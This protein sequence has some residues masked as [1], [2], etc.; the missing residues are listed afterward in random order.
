MPKRFKLPSP[1]MILITIGGLILFILG[2]GSMEMSVDRFFSGIVNMFH[3]IISAF[4]PDLERL[5]T[6]LVAMYETFQIALV[7]TVFGV[8]L[9]LPIALLAS[10]NTTPHPAIGYVAKGF[11]SLLRT[12]P[13]LIWALIFVISVGLGPFP[14]MLTIMVDTIGFCGRFFS[15]RI[16]EME[17]GPIEAVQ[18]TGSNQTGVIFGSV[19]PLGVPS[20]V[21]TSLFAVEKAIRGAVVLGLVGAGGIGVELSVAM[22]MR[23]FDEALMMIL[24]ILVVVIIVEQC[25][26]YI[27]KKFIAN[28]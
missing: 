14:G 16:E 21:G 4:P 25:S 7:G 23:Q 6:A 1:P 13:D 27:R 20:F 22:T 10:R 9:S 28:A 11:I 2:L 8:I 18:S 17:K 3:F 12:V 15:E 24:L 26:T 19:L 5:Q